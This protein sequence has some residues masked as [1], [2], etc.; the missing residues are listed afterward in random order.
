MA[1]DQARR[2]HPGRSALQAGVVA[3][4]VCLASLVSAQA[5]SSA[6][7]A[8]GHATPAP[9]QRGLTGAAT[10]EQIAP[11]AAGQGYWMVA[12]NG[13]VAS[14]GNAVGYGSVSSL[15]A[16]RHVVGMAPTPDDHGYWL[17]GADGGI[18]AFGDAGY[19]GSTGALPL[20]RPIVGMA[21]TADG[22]G[23]WL[24]ASDGGIFAFGDAAFHGSTGALTLNKPI[25]GMAATAD[26]AGYWLVAS[27][28]GIFAFGDAAF[29]GSTGNLTLNEPVTGMAVTPHGQGY[30]LVA[31]DGGIFAFGDA[32][33]HGSM[34]G[35]ALDAPVAGMAPTADGGGYWMVGADGGIFAFGD[36][37]F[38]GSLIASGPASPSPSPSPSTPGAATPTSTGNPSAS[39][40][41]TPDFLDV[42]YPHTTSTTCTDEVVQATDTA[43]A[44]EGLGPLHLPGDFSVLSPAEQLFV[45]TDIERV[46]R[47][48][49]PV[50]GLD[51]TLSVDAAGGAVANTDPSP[52]QVPSGMGLIAWGSNWAENGNPL[53]SNYFWMYDDGEGSGNI[54]C[55]PSNTAGCWGHREN[56]LGLSS[57]QATYGGTLLMGAAEDTGASHGGW[58]SDTELIVLASGPVS[59]LDYTWAD[60]VAD[61]AS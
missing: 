1:V 11:S 51:P 32:A 40:P 42:C 7:P 27:D 59:A 24:V 3:V 33:F 14:F 26:G 36:A 43:R 28:G 45:L 21:P 54:D 61:G 50:V 35:S 60:A 12:A 56:I 31:S 2:S 29:H 44:Q 6:A 8:A 13:G 55:T 17:V 37:P 23:Y 15:P 9:P 22:R 57:Y 34:G 19:F 38:F 58:V 4:L 47:G 39:I 48:L 30:W 18:F 46:D 16:G 10:V 53:G 49:P 20:N 25:V 5:T 41:P 52:T